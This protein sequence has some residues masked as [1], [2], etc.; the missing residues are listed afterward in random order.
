M[1]D[2]TKKSKAQAVWEYISEHPQAK[3]QDTAKALSKQ[4]F[5]V[6]AR[7]VSQI[8]SRAKP[9]KHRSNNQPKVKRVEPKLSRRAAKYPR[10]NL[11]RALRIPQAILEQNAGRE[12]TDKESAPFIG[13]KYNKGP[14]LTELSSCIKFGLL[15]RPRPGHLELTDLARQILRPQSPEDKLD[16]LRQAVRNAPEISEVYEHYRGEN[17]PDD[18]FLT[19]ALIDKFGIPKANVSDFKTIF[20]ETLKFANLIEEKGDKLRIVDVTAGADLSGKAADRLKAM[21]KDIKVSQADTCFVMMPFSLPLGPYYS[22]IYKPAIEKAGLTPIRADEDI[23]STGKIIDQIWR[24]IN[25]AKVLVAE[26]TSRNANVFYEL[27]LAHALKKPVVLVSSNENDV[28]FDLHYIRV[29]YYDTTDPFWGQK[30]IDKIAEN[31]ISAL[32]NPEDALF[33]TALTQER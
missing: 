23:F 5:D 9:A 27:G 7:Y 14:Y 20:L 17:L 2:V 8:K 16:G 10:H 12:C 18:E 25:S 33:K 15:K 24:G 4:G 26:L 28:P 1:P 6:S 32:K 13:V 29:I 21:S 11:E 3:V 31:V 19:N 22:L 30:L